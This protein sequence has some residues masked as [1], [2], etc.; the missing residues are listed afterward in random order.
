MVQEDAPHRF[1]LFIETTPFPEPF[2]QLTRR[3]F[4]TRVEGVSVAKEEG[5]KTIVLEN[6]RSKLPAAWQAFVDV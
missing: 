5:G 3:V 2:R 4:S 1:A 6:E